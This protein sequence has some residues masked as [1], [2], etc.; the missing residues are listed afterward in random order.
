M[1]KRPKQHQLED[2]SRIKFQSCLPK[3]WVIRNKDKDYGIDCEVELFDYKGEAQGLIFYVQLKA[4]SSNRESEI[5]NINL[6]IDTLK[7]FSQLEI[8]VLL[9][10]YS[11]HLD[12]I[13]IKWVNNVDLTFIKENSKTHNIKMSENDAWNEKSSNQIEIDLNN[14]R[15]LKSGSFNFPI[16]Y[17]INID[18]DNIHGISKN[19]FKIQLRN[20]LNQFPDTLYYKKYDKN[21]LINILI[22]NN[23]LLIQP[24]ILTGVCFHSLERRPNEAFV[25]NLSL[26]IL[27]GVSKCM[28]M[29]GQIDF[30][31]KI[32]FDNDL[33]NRLIE[34]EEILLNILPHLLSSSYFENTLNLINDAIDKNEIIYLPA[35]AGLLLEL[36]KKNKKR[37]KLIELFF[38]SQLE[39]TKNQNLDSQIATSHYNLGNFYRNNSRFFDSIHH[40]ICAK[41][42]DSRYLKRSYFY[43]DIAGICFDLGKF[44]FSSIFYYKSLELGA[45]IKIKSL[46]ADALMFSGE[47]EKAGNVFSEYITESE[48]PCEEFLLKSILLNRIILK[49]SITSQKRLPKEA[50]FYADV[51][52]LD[53]TKKRLRNLEKAL[54]YDLLSSLAWYNIGYLN[55]ENSD[56][57]KAMYGFAMAAIINL[58]DIEAWTNAYVSFLNLNEEG[59]L[60]I[61]MLILKTAY[62]HN[63][64]DFLL[65]LYRI[66]EHSNIVSIDDIEN[67]LLDDNVT[68][69][70]D[71]VL[72][73][74]ND[75]YYEEIDFGI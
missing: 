49:Q 75:D 34:K 62:Y 14:T 10:R 26:D 11:N 22:K 27:I 68:K 9:A 5:L 35:Y 53:S 17:S 41:E 67:I 43:S 19:N 42:Y 70:K 37:I 46:Y 8:P 40:Y 3:E 58:D 47:F 59:D 54:N 56:F 24:S 66:L 30:G 1:P 74:L 15:I 32:I 71:C 60:L 57:E 73:I 38:L 48:K 50:S 39:K 21:Y 31:A 55:F 20:T 12:K 25:E 29:L 36:T 23:K 65:Y 61:G 18:D 16:S 6:R 64:D 33:G 45:S 63:H 7:Y 13:F 2:F 72:R 51:E 44:N 69:K 4:T 28:V 52:Q